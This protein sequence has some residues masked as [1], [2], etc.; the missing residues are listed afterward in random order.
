[1]FV[2]N[3]F[4]AIYIDIYIINIVLVLIGDVKMLITTSNPLISS[5]PERYNYLNVS[6]IKCELMCINQQNIFKIKELTTKSHSYTHTIE[7]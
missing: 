6:S 3:S 4:Q 2:D 5:D 7:D 1:M